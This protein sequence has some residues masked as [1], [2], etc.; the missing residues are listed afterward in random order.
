MHCA[1]LQRLCANEIDVPVGKM[2][3]TAM[4]NSRGGFESDLTVM[5]L[6]ADR[7]QL[8]TGSAQP[9]RDLDWIERH[10]DARRACRRHRRQ[11]ADRVLS[12]MG[13]RARELMRR[14]SPDDLSP[15][16][17]EFS[18][19]REIDLGLARVRA[20]RMSYVGGPGCELYVPVGDGAPRLPGA[21]R[22]GTGSRPA[23]EAGRLRGLCDAGYYAIDALRIEAGR[24]AW[25]AELGPDETPWEA[26][27]GFAVKLRKPSGFI[28]RDALARLARRSRCARSCSAS[29]STIQRAWVW[30]GEAMQIDGD[31]RSASSARRAGDMRPDAA[32]RSATCAAR[33]RSM[34]MRA[35]RC[36]STCGASRSLR[37]LGTT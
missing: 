26:G 4:L 20:A 8:I 5:R 34:F 32:S 2:V 19:T 12:L 16:G 1:L 14:V 29:C 25:G 30:G 9:Q 31:C 35:R 17:L 11:R 10:I 21:A 13:P 15:Q 36:R 22:G 18:H 7:F 33:L 27:L 24:R 23:D 28:G 37:R 3:Y 6:G